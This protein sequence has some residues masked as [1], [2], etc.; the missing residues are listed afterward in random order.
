MPNDAE[1]LGFRIAGPVILKCVVKSGSF[2]GTAAAG[3]F[4]VVTA[5]VPTSCVISPPCV[6]DKYHF[7]HAIA[8]LF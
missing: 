2:I 4:C 1:L 8:A 3:L 7:I 5:P 6:L